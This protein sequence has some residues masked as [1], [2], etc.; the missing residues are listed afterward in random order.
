MSQPNQQFPNKVWDGRTNNPLRSANANRNVPPDYND[1]DRLRI[2]IIRMQEAMIAAGVIDSEGG[3]GTPDPTVLA[4]LP[5]PQLYV[6][7]R[8]RNPN[9]IPVATVITDFSLFPAE[10]L[11][12]DNVASIEQ[13]VLG[14]WD[15]QTTLPAPAGNDNWTVV[16][17]CESDGDADGV[18]NFHPDSNLPWTDS[19]FQVG[20][21]RGDEGAGPS[22]GGAYTN[23][24][25]E[26]EV[27]GYHE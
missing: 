25:R 23:A 16:V 21:W 4:P 12:A 8:I 1:F 9:A 27:F 15:I 17:H 19:R 5:I 22:S 14:L 18:R 13:P 24:S 7:L 20:F 10:I 11:R 26:F 2:E 3:S 6:R